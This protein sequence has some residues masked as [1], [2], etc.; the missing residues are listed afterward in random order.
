MADVEGRSDGLFLY[1]QTGRGDGGVHHNFRCEH[2]SVVVARIKVQL[3]L[4]LES[5]LRPATHVHR[6]QPTKFVALGRRR[7]QRRSHNPIFPPATIDDFLRDAVAATSAGTDHGYHG[8]DSATGALPHVKLA[9]GGSLPGVR[10]GFQ[11][12]VGQ[13]FVIMLRNGEAV[14]GATPREWRTELVALA[15]AVNWG[16]GDLFP[17]YGMP[18]LG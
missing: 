4:L 13:R 1:E 15:D 10:T 9:K 12:K 14:D 7:Q 2:W 16:S 17:Q 18:S 6:E 11:G 5:S 8:F 3:C